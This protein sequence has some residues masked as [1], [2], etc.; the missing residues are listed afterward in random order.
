[1]DFQRNK[2]HLVIQETGREFAFS[3]ILPPGQK[4]EREDRILP[5]SM[6]GPGSPI[7]EGWLPGSGQ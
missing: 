7:F 1:M 4:I 5:E 3:V 6:G 2:K